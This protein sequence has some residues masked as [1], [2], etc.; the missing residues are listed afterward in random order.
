MTDKGY[1]DKIKGKTKETVGDLRGDDKQKAE[2]ILDQAIGK[3]K[4][5]T[6]DI[7]ESEDFIDETKDKL[8]K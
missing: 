8:N 6:S 1:T 2:G 7:K 4:E 5:V 3:T